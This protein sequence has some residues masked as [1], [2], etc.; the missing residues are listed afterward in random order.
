[1]AT[2]KVKRSSVEGRI[3][4]TTDLELGEFAV[5]TH[6]GKLFLKRN[7][8]LQDYIVEVGGTQGFDVI[9]QTA[10]T[11]T[12]GTL[13]RFA[14]TVGAS[15]KLLIEPFLANNTYSSDYFMGVVQETIP[16]GSTGFVIDHG[17]IRGVNTSAYAPGT[18][19]YASSTTA[20]AFTS[21]QPTAPNNKITVAAVINQHANNGT[22]QIRISRGSQLGN[23]EL[24][25]LDSLAQDQ[26]LVYNNTAGRFENSGVKT[27]NG[28]SLFGTGDIEIS[29]AGGTALQNRYSYTA[30]AAQTTFSAEYT[31]PYVDVYLNGLRLSSGVDYTATNGTAIVLTDAAV[32]NDLVE[33][34][35]QVATTT[36]LVDDTK[37][38]LAG[39][40]MTGAISFA[41][42]QTFPGTQTAL[43][44][45]TSIK[46][47]N[48]QSVL[49][50][51]N[52]QIDGGVTSF[53][54]RT[55]AVT[56]GSL[57]VTTALGFTPVAQS[58][59]D[60]SISALVASAPSTLD[61]LNELAAALGNDANFATTVTNSIA[62]KLPLS[63]GTLTGSV[64]L[65]AG[66]ASG[67]A[68]LNSSKVLTTDTKL[69]F[70]GTR[71][72]LGLSVVPQTGWGS[73][74]RAI[75]IGLAA[76]ISSATTG[77][78]VNISINAFDS[79]TGWKYINSAVAS[80]Y[81]QELGAHVWRTAASGTA[82]NAISWTEVARFTA[83]GAFSPGSAGNNTGTS[84]QVLTS[85]G[86][87]APPTWANPA[88]SSTFTTVVEVNPSAAA[89]SG[90]T[91]LTLGRATGYKYI[92]SWNLE[93]LNLN[94]VGNAVQVAGN[95]VV[96]AGNYTSYSP[97]LTGGSASGTWGI[98]VTGSAGSVAWSGITSK[99]TTVSGYGITNALVR[100]GGLGNIDFN[101]QRTLASG[102]YSVDSAPTNGPGATYS[103][104]IQ[105]YERGDTAA[106]LVIDYSSGR[107]Y[108]RG[109]QTATPTY[110]P[111]RTQLDD[112]NFT[113]Y[114]PA[115]I[116]ANR[117]G[118][119]KLYRSDDDSGYN[120]QTH[121]S[122]DVSGYWSLRGYLNDSY[123]APCYV[124]LSGRSNRANGFF[125]IDDNYGVGVVGL[126]SAS[127]YQTVYAMGDAYK[128]SADGTSLANMYGM[129]WSH[130]N[131]GGAAGNLTDH[132]MLII[133]NGGF[134]CAISNSI[135]ASGNITAYSDE[136]LKT[137]W[138][139]MPP[140]FVA[141]LAQVKVG[142]YDRIDGE[143]GTQ[144]G[145]SAQSFQQ[146]LPQAI[147]T[148]KDE[149]QTLSVSY[150]NAALASAVELAKDNVDLRARITRLESLIEQLLRKE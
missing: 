95:V 68:Y 62:D 32:V 54:T 128:M 150:G 111:W 29:G 134:R 79:Q 42:G 109:I 27:I 1:M 58:A 146:L 23:D 92:Q 16:S 39:G 51:G 48:G 147:M 127:R 143:N 119:T 97:T 21:T 106:Q 138:R 145:V 81:Y 101:A 22:L 126:Y 142:V 110:S 83:T 96:H 137:N 35:A 14:G 75:Q 38:P 88:A 11:I 129:A 3:P 78:A 87:G 44:S 24:V 77:S 123:H 89:P 93:P 10:N 5:N 13:V 17:K 124:A 66:T 84:G 118:V 65:S 94:P 60:A 61:T 133:N 67:V 46:T 34:V 18:I 19:L 104:F 120:I 28:E 37:L 41:A 82:G 107:L 132:G 47:V 15:G 6:D 43:V 105:M 49:G 55:G 64:T 108:T 116:S 71:G 9:N 25:E 36:V 57:D 130:P 100:G 125:Y 99:P 63:G 113:N 7:D 141:R 103:N 86:S 26:T 140:N 98:S 31:A 117:P 112:G 72:V 4:L 2:I 52:I 122:P 149:M 148:A 30:T 20:G 40:T 91:S 8:S 144:V 12:K 69:V 135:V 73:T 114:A 59:I 90:G 50:S 85:A 70:D 136:R 45:G 102:I 56:L 33:I 131:A 80:N 53:N 115:R 76:A 74:S 139:A 121:W